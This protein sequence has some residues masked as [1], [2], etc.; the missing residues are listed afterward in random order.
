VT[1]TESFVAI[2]I[3]SPPLTWAEGASD[4]VFANRE[5][6][7]GD[8]GHVPEAESGDAVRSG[9]DMRATLHLGKRNGMK[10]DVAAF[11]TPGGVLGH[12]S[13]SGGTLLIF[14]C[15]GSYGAAH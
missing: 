4:T 2:V 8:G 5:V 15:I 9:G 7:W 13:V 1:V 3:F 6:P 10:D 14:H 11:T 12:P